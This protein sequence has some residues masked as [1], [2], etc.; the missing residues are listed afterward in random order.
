M[1]KSLRSKWKKHTKSLKAKKFAPAVADR[2]AKLNAK[3]EMATERK[4]GRNV[5]MQEDKLTGFKHHVPKIDV[6]APLVL[7]PLTTRVV[8]YGASRPTENNRVHA[9]HP[10][11]QPA[12]YNDPVEEGN[13]LK[14]LAALAEEGDAAPT[15]EMAE[16]EDGAI[17]MS[18]GGE[19]GMVNLSH[20]TAKKKNGKKITMDQMSTRLSSSTGKVD[21]AA[22]DKTKKSAAKR[23]LK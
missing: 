22:S 18:F 16:D 6:G 2:V 3:L 13:K 1:A 8:T 20:A 12:R 4:L 7:E 21:A 10:E 11:R 15:M 14:A 5:A 17:V 23:K 9:Q 19:G